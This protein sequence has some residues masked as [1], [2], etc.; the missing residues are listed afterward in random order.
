MEFSI[1]GFPVEPWVI[2]VA[3][4]GWFCWELGRLWLAL[5]SVVWPKV[6]GK[7]LE[8]SIEVEADSDGDDFY[9]PRVRY[10]YVVR[11]ELYYG[12]RLAFH[13]RGSYREADMANAMDGIVAG[14]QHRVYYH[15]R[16]PRLSVLKPGASGWSYALLAILLA[17]VVI[18]MWFQG[19]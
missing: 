15:R 7:V 4:L 19:A 13:P 10:S 18:A 9:V 17:V 1:F 2:A 12:K 5:D 16:H 14:S 3:A 6:L 11:G 8:A